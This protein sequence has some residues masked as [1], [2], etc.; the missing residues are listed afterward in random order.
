MNIYIYLFICLLQ[1][2][3]SQPSRI[4]TQNFTDYSIQCIFEYQTQNKSNG[5]I[6]KCFSSARITQFNLTS[7]LKGKPETNIRAKEKNKFQIQTKHQ[8]NSTKKEMDMRLFNLVRNSSSTREEM[9]R[10]GFPI[11]SRIPAQL[12]EEAMTM[13][14]RF[15]RRGLDSYICSSFVKK[16]I[17]LL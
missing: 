12:L 10:S 7:D 5:Y 6:G 15:E 3:E 16:M 14:L 17:N 11:P 13:N 8:T 4:W 1:H 2:L 9:S